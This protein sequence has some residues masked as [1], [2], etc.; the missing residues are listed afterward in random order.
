M[1]PIALLTALIWI[2]LGSFFL[3]FWFGFGFFAAL[4]CASPYSPVPKLDVSAICEWDKSCF[5]V[6]ETVPLVFL[7]SGKT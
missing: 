7:V 3:F 2:W 6:N 1:N 5:L 4:V